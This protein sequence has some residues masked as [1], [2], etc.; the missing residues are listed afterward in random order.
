VKHQ[1]II[2]PAEAARQLGDPD[3]LFI[4]CRSTLG[5]AGLGRISYLK[6]HIPDSVYADLE[7]NLSGQVEPGKTGRHPLPEKTKFVEFISGLGIT[8][9]TQ[10]IAYDD[11]SGAMAAA[12]LWWLLKWAGHEYVAVLNGGLSAW[13]KAGLP[14]D[15]RPPPP[16][17]ETHFKARFRDDIVVDAAEVA[18]ITHKHTLV[19]SRTNDR[20][21]GE[22]ET[23][24]PIAGHIPGA[25]SLPYT[26]NLADDGSFRSAEQLRERFGRLRRGSDTE[27]IFYCGSGVTAAHSLLAFTVAFSEMPK[28]Y[29][30]S[31]S[32][33]ITDPTRGV[34]SSDEGSCT[35]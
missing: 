1:S 12:R 7:K 21:R 8:A 16:R 26:G 25:C 23:I 20:Y 32:E 31:W 19:D 2:E 11:M 30:G 29:A 27:V 28:L 24:D 33:W 14:T 6:E 13:K 35:E 4:D 18:R 5:Q 3:W 22:N 15:D 9:D 17:H 10:V 34:A